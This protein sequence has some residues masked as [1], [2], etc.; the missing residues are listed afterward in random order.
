[1]DDGYVIPGLNED[2][3]LGGAK[4]FEWIAGVCMALVFSEVFLTKMARQMPVLGGILVCTTFGLATLRRH[5]PDEERGIRNFCMVA[6][7]ICP[8][9]L[10]A[11]AALQPIWSGSPVR[12]LK[13]D[14]YYM[15]LGL[16]NLFGLQDYGKDDEAEGG[17]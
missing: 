5:F 10:P 9:N 13:A 17:A 6:M 1:M 2:W 16:H 8:P 11:P 7:G 12:T 15:Q 14:S 4:L 3:T